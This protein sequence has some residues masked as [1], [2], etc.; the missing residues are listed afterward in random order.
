MWVELPISM[1]LVQAT[2]R[3]PG[4]SNYQR[5]ELQLAAATAI[6]VRKRP[7]TAPRWLF[8]FYAPNMDLPI[9]RLLWEV[10]QGSEMCL[11]ITG[12]RPG[13]SSWWRRGLQQD[14]QAA[15]TAPR[16]RS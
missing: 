14:V 2:G 15:I 10:V 12:P 9:H 13:S 3:R 5:W 4:S 7:S 16:P 11:E 6:T 8:S 1:T